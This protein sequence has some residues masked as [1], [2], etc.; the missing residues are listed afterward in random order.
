MLQA[1]A[2]G[3]SGGSG[4][5]ITYSGSTATIAANIPSIPVATIE[6]LSL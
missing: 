2:M 1:D 6:A 3:V 5:D 4:V